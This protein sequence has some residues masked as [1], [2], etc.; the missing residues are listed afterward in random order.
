MKEN[1]DLR[2]CKPDLLIKQVIR[3]ISRP[4]EPHRLNL[5][6]KLL[7]DS[8]ELTG[9]IY[10]K[11]FSY[12]WFS[13]CIFEPENGNSPEACKPLFFF[14]DGFAGFKAF[15]LCGFLNHWRKDIEGLGTLLNI[16]SDLLPLPE[17]PCIVCFIQ[18][19]QDTV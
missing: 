12:Y 5:K 3:P 15:L 1:L 8:F 7:N 9:D 4:A 16:P 10:L 13:V 18:V 11:L 17:A 2:G 6:P 19:H 14:P